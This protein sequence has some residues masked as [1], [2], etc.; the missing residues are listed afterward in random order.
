MKILHL[1]KTYYPMNHGGVEA[2]IHAVAEHAIMANNSVEIL[3]CGK[4]D[5]PILT[6]VKGSYVMISIINSFSVFYVSK[7]IETQKNFDILHLHYPFIMLE[8]ISAINQ[9]KNLFY[10]LPF[11]CSKAQD[12]CVFFQTFFKNF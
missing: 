12:H 11:G 5:E 7:I 9:F 10:N 8:V 6:K 4:K 1:F 3:I 2:V